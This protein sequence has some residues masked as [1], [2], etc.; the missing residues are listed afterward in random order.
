VVR[1]KLS[2]QVRTLEG[3]R[4]LQQI[5]PAHAAHLA[6]FVPKAIERDSQLR[7]GLQHVGQI[8][9]AQQI[10]VTNAQRAQLAAWGKQQDVVADAAIK[11]DFPEFASDEAYERLRQASRKAL[12]RVGLSKADVESLWHNGTLRSVPAQRMIAGLAVQELQRDRRD[13]A[14]HRAPVAPVQRPGVARPAGSGSIETI[15]ALERQLGQATTER[16]SLRIA[17]K[18]TQARRALRG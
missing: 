18:L 16:E 1:R 12:A 10:Q 3:F 6:E 4:Q 5:N 9:A 11:K 17:T 14:A 8:R 13:L 2:P 7:S 15:H